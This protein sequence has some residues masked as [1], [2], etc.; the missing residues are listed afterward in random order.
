MRR[1]FPH[2]ESQRIWMERLDRFRRHQG[3]M[4]EFCRREGITVAGLSY[5]LKKQTA[6]GASPA[7]RRPPLSAFA[8]V[9]I[10]NEGNMPV[11]ESR[12]DLP[13][14]R[15]TAEFLKHLLSTGTGAQR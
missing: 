5:W 2:T 7:L 9:E 4:S 11:Y 8:A 1:K 13:D 6:S 3:S 15:W 12:G 10:V 14:P